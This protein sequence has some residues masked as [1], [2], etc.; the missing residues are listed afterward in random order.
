MF[1]MIL[2]SNV[3]PRTLNSIVPGSCTMSGTLLQNGFRYTRMGALRAARKTR[4]IFLVMPRWKRGIAYLLVC[5]AVIMAT[6]GAVG[7]HH[8]YF[9]RTNL[10]DIGPF[11]RFE[12]PAIGRI[13]DVNDQPLIEVAGQYR[14]ITGYGDIPPI[15]RDAILA[16][17]DKNFFYHNGVDYSGIPRVLGKVR[18]GALAA[19]L[20]RP[21]QQ[22]EVNSPAIFP[23]GGSTITQQLVRGHF[24]QNMTTQENSNRLRHDGLLSRALS[25][26]IGPRN[27]N[28]MVRKIEEIRLSLWIERDAGLFWL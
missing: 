6:L 7:L 8:I 20:I 10:P 15:V 25:Y 4:N 13:Y 19:R 23:Q 14:Q 12:F 3:E 17:E 27:V 16:A 11:T 9:D 5:A 22:D 18:I 26:V 1:T 2:N 24:L 28:M 21:G